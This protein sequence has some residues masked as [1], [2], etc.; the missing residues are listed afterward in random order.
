MN[1]YKIKIAL[2]IAVALIAGF[3]FYYNKTNF[4]YQQPF[5]LPDINNSAQKNLDNLISLNSAQT[6]ESVLNDTQFIKISIIGGVNNPGIYKFN[7]LVKLREL[8][9]RA[10]GLSETAVYNPLKYDSI[11]LQDNDTVV[12]PVKLRYD[13][14]RNKFEI[15][16]EVF[17]NLDILLNRNRVETVKAAREKSEEPLIININNATVEEIMLLPNIGKKTAEKIVDYRARNGKF[18]TLEEIT[19]VPGIG[20]KKLESFKSRITVK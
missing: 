18:K 9:S 20:R 14:Y 7:G 1:N 19:N 11:I 10:G 12:I 3:L 2:I 5:K 8:I 15:T 13:N 17:G 4:Y 6:T 16:N